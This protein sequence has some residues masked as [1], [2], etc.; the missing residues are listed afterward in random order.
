MATK[1]NVENTFGMLSPAYELGYSMTRLITGPLEG[2]WHTDKYYQWLEEL[3]R[4]AR[5]RQGADR[6][7][8]DM[9]QNIL[10]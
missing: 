8:M 1:T 6:T 10:L 2:H 3:D 7:I 9:H 4:R 5:E